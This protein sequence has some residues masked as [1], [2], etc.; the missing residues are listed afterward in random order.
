MPIRWRLAAV[1]K[2]QGLTPYRLAKRTGLSVPTCYD[3]VKAHE[4][5]RIDAHTLALLCEHLK[6]Q[7]GDL[8]DYR[9]R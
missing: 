3:L 5:G 9:K 2:A 4:P 7:P 8:L 1:L 6:V